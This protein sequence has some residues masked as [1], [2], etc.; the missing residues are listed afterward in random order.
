MGGGA[1]SPFKAVAPEGVLPRQCS[2]ARVVHVVGTV[3]PADGTVL[4]SPFGEHQ[5]SA[6]QVAAGRQAALHGRSTA[7]NNYGSFRALAAE[8]RQLVELP[9]ADHYLRPLPGAAPGDDPVARL[10]DQWLLPWLR[11]R[12]P[13]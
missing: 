5:G 7:G 10:C 8:D 9:D 11:E 4:R 3:V 13:A 2:S 12:W 1:S 6:I